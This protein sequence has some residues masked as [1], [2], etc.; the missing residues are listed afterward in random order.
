MNMDNFDKDIWFLHRK[1]FHRYVKYAKYFRQATEALAAFQKAVRGE[2]KKKK[3]RVQELEVPEV[4][5]ISLLT[6]SSEDVSEDEDEGAP[7]ELVS[8]G[9]V[10][11]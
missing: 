5:T 4:E 9:N 2:E 11:M 3:K 8:V 7:E 10:H 1:L 6:S